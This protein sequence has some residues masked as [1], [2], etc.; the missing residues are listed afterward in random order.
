MVRWDAPISSVSEVLTQPL[1]DQRLR[2]DALR[3]RLLRQPFIDLRRDRDPA[4]SLSS[5]LDFDF[6]SMLPVIGQT[7]V[8]LIGADSLW[9]VRL[10][11]TAFFR[12]SIFVHIVYVLCY[13][14]LAR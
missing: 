12:V 9:S 4:W 14:Y 2:S 3:A 8:I 6:V 13:P 1:I 11:N 7:V 10:R 5:H